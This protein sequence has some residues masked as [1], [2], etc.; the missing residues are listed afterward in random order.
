MACAPPPARIDHAL[1]LHVYR[2]FVSLTN[3]EG[4]GS[5]GR[6]SSGGCASA[7]Y[8]PPGV[9][10]MS[11][12]RLCMAPSWGPVRVRGSA[13]GGCFYPHGR[14]LAVGDALLRGQCAVMGPFP[15]FRS[16]GDAL[17]V[18]A[19]HSPTVGVALGDGQQGLR[20][21]IRVNWSQNHLSKR[22][23]IAHTC[24]IPVSRHHWAMIPMS[25]RQQVS[26]SVFRK[27]QKRND[28]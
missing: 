5:Q 20:L 11:M 18:I 23:R 21:G 9:G 12:Q 6:G 14:P 15:A 1:D 24:H 17:R 3:R 28:E 2:V 27:Q 8:P 7:A 26:S 22:L 16:P 19:A 25:G 4:N 10:C 13:G